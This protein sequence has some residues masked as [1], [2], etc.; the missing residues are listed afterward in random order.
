[1]KKY[2]F[3]FIN[4]HSLTIYHFIYFANY[5]II[6]YLLFIIYYLLFTIYY[7]LFIIYYLLINTFFIIYYI[8]YSFM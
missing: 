2:Q 8:Y 7:L 1:M 5:S 3:I 4:V 6:Y